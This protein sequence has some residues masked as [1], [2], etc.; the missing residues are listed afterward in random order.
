MRRKTTSLIWNRPAT[1]KASAPTNQRMATL[2]PAS[3]E[4]YG[5][6]HQDRAENAEENECIRGDA[7]VDWEAGRSEF[8]RRR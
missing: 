3:Y 2:L 5:A 8:Q 1:R 7:R 6:D 4:R